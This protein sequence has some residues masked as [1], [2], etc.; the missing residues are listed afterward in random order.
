MDT[1]ARPPAKDFRALSHWILHCANSGVSRVDFLREITGMLLESSECDAVE[2]RV[3]KE[4][5]CFRCEATR[6][7]APPFT[8]EVMRCGPGDRNALLACAPKSG[9]LEAICRLILRKQPPSSSPFFTAGGSFWSGNASRA[10]RRVLGP[11]AAADGNAPDPDREYGSLVVIPLPGKEET[12]GLVQLKSKKQDFFDAGGVEF[13]ENVA[14]TLGL[15][16]VN[17][18]AHSALRERV[19][20]LTCLYSLA[21]LAERPGITLEGILQG[22]AE[23]LPPSWQYPEI[24]AARITLDGS[25]YGTPQ[26]REGPQEQSA[27]ILVDGRRRGSVDVVYLD[28]TPELDEGPFLKE[29]RSLIDAVARQIAL[30]IERRQAA[31]EKT[32]LEDQL[33]HADR[34]ATIGQLSAGVAHELNEPL[35]NILAFAQ[36]AQ[37]YPELPEPTASDLEKIVAAS[38]HAREVVKKLML[39]ARQ[40]PPQKTRVNLNAVVEEGLY[41]LESRCSK[42]GVTLQRRLSPQLPQIVADPSQ[43]NQVLVNLVVNAIQAMAGGGKL[44]IATRA[45]RTHVLLTV[46]DNG[47]GMSEEV[48]GR[49]FIPFFTTKD[50]HEGTGLGLPVA[51]GIVNSHGGMIAVESTPGRGTR[52]EIQLPVAGAEEDKEREPDDSAE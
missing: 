14:Q 38:L 18:I 39:F 11:D 48:L 19:K 7:S 1:S 46:E 44:E 28:E 33:R 9:D 25:C 41:F 32:R 35:G 27:D 17:Q 22:I 49:I 13:Y 4:D 37:K 21:Q 52:F 26:F 45:S 20:E 30:I 36:L 29:E 43:L 31:D 2:L 3:R 34:L 23:L 24:T 40:M 16:L 6:E 50:I 42:H 51:H 8:I 15:A 5:K 12:I 47:I 10:I